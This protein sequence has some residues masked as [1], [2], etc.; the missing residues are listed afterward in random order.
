MSSRATQL[1]T[2]GL[3]GML[4]GVGLPLSGMTAPRKVLGFLDFAGDW[5]PSL[6]FVMAGA[7]GVHFA[8]YRLIRRRRRPLFA[9]AFTVPAPGRTDGKLLV[10]S[11]LFGVGWGLA[12]YCPGPGIA[13][14][15]SGT[16]KAL[17]FVVAMLAGLLIGKHIERRLQRRADQRVPA[18]SSAPHATT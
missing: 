14:L 7:V 4:F 12:G 18:S 10:G 5:D 13:S 17:V 16:L 8:A 3:A 6:A 15:G 1:G 2:A 11:A 9:E